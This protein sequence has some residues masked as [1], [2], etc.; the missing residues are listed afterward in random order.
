MFIKMSHRIIEE[1]FYHTH[2]DF[3]TIKVL[4]VDQLFSFVDS[5]TYMSEHNYSK[6]QT[7]VGVTKR[8]LLDT[9]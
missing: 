9:F 6:I 7:K 8:V 4:A 1:V 2:I 3:T 5:Y